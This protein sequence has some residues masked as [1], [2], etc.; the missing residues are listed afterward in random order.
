MGAILFDLEELF[1][2]AALLVKRPGL[3][4]VLRRISR[5]IG[6]VSDRLSR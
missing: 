2:D 1:E 6:S 5:N 3:K 4:R